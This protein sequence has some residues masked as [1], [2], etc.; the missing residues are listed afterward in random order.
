MPNNPS[1]VTLQVKP[2]V[3]AH[4]S[5]GSADAVTRP[6]SGRPPEQLRCRRLGAR[7]DIRARGDEVAT[8]RVLDVEGAADLSPGLAR[9]VLDGGLDEDADAVG[10]DRASRSARRRP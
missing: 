8:R 1:K 9:V 6:R 7:G 5:W 3:Q 2:F 10:L 4:Q